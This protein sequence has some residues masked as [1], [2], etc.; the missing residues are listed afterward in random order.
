MRLQATKAGMLW[1]DR[2]GDRR[3][4]TILTRDFLV[5]NPSQEKL[6]KFRELLSQCR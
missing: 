5:K 1:V 4:W 6:N 2:T 3:S